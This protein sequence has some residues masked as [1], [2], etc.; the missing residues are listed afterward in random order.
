MSTT[1][2]RPRIIV[3]SAA[4]IAAGA[5]LAAANVALGQH[6]GTEP[7]PAPVAAAKPASSDAAETLPAAPAPQVPAA[8]PA[9]LR[10]APAPG[11]K[12]PAPS[13]KAPTPA[14]KAPAPAAPGGDG[15]LT[16]DEM[17]TATVPALCGTEGGTL[18]NGYLE[19]HQRRMTVDIALDHLPDGTLDPDT[20][21]PWTAGGR[22]GSGQVAAVSCHIGD[23]HIG[24]HIVAWNGAG[25]VIGSVELVGWNPGA[26]DRTRSLVAD[27]DRLT[28]EHVET[29]PQEYPTF[30]DTTDHRVV[31]ERT[32][33]GLQIDESTH[34]WN[35]PLNLG[36]T[37][38]EAVRT[39]DRA[40]ETR[41]A[42]AATSERL[43]QPLSNG[44]TLRQLIEGADGGQLL[45]CDEQATP[46]DLADGTR[47]WRCSDQIGT[48]GTGPIYTMDIRRLGFL[49]WQVVAVDYIEPD[50]G[51]DGC[52]GPEG[53]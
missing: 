36:M 33:D 6:D 12:V 3:A 8:R 26:P 48:D 30:G 11:S 20:V 4:V 31:L 34:E 10:D 25:D 37:F 44:P 2:T 9:V 21:V 14:T 7:A 52:V 43:D 27:G 22:D 19:A 23:Q 53:C 17:L 24:E 5:V 1:G 46:E 28:V 51:G 45:W 18:T 35:D 16:V 42:T 47:T 13:A 15:I 32:R 29:D 41:I 49:D 38:A 40:R 50:W 39:G